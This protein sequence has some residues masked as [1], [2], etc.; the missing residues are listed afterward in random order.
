MDIPKNVWHGLEFL[1]PAVLLE[2]KEGPFVEHE[3]DGI[4]EIRK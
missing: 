4:L 1:E 2:S 3:V